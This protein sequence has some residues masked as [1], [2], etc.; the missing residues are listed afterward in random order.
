MSVYVFLAEGFEE[1]EALTPVDYLRR[2]G[3]EVKTLSCGD[4][5]TVRGSHDIS[6]VADMTAEEALKQGQKLEA[7]IIPGGM[8][9]AANVGKSTAAKE[10]IAQV[11]GA[12]KI[13]AAICAAPVVTL[14]STGLLKGKKFT[15]YPSMEEQLEQWGGS[16][17]KELTEGC[18]YTGNRV[19]VDGNLITGAGPGA[20]EEF[21]LV[22]AKTLVGEEAA[23]KLASSA[24][25]RK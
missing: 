9:G 4:S 8:P 24:L 11:A 3:L 16:N 14:A 6:V 17:W 25:F 15:C 23:Q 19:E 2:V 21:A 7:V 20:A 18:Q 22:L 10:L 5:L 12:G 1:I 13:L